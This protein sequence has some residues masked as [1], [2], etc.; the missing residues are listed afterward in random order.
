MTEKTRSRGLLVAGIDEAGRGPLAG[1]V[2][3]A[4]VVLPTGYNH[5]YIRDS[6]KLSPKKREIL[7]E[8]IK[9]AAL[10]W[11]VVAVG[12]RRIDSLNILQA[13]RLAMR[14]AAER[15]DADEFWIDGNVEIDIDK[16]QRCIVRGDAKHIQ[17]AAASILAKVWRD[18]LMEKISRKYPGYGFEKHMGYPTKAHFKA[19]ERLY[20]C[21]V[22]RKSFRPVSAYF[23]N[24]KV[25]SKAHQES[26]GKKRRKYSPFI[27]EKKQLLNC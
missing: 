27:S 16:P 15:V 26:P 5:S 7:F 17:I 24:G 11:S 10:S 4:A 2:V 3:A 9:S 14:L 1:P 6:K 21:R 25:S 20:P 18:R 8:E 22:H 13:T 12:H 19:I 23:K